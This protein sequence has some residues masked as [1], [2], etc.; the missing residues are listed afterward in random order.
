MEQHW[1]GGLLPDY[2]GETFFMCLQTSTAN[3]LSLDINVDVCFGVSHTDAS[4]S[5]WTELGN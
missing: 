2:H 4:Y 1:N 5:Q 3:Y